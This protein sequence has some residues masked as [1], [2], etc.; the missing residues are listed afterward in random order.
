MAQEPPGRPRGRP[1]SL[2][3]DTAIDAA[4]HAYWRGVEHPSLNEVARRVGISKPALYREFGGEDGLLA[5]GLE[6]YRA[7][8][9]VPTLATLS[10]DGPFAEVLRDE[11]RDAYAAWCR[12][13]LARGREVDPSLPAE[14]SGPARAL[15]RSRPAVVEHG[16][17]VRR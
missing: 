3:R 6:R 9:I 1:K 10:S 11:L 13:A 2:D 17:K 7:E 5:A 12:R 14:R 16:R 15:T 4:M 8:V